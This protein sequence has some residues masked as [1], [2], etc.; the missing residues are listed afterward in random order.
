MRTPVVIVK[1]VLVVELFVNGQL[2]SLPEGF[3]ATIG[4]T[5]EGLLTGMCVLML[6]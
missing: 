5:E 1:P 4:T 6:L 2:A 3:G